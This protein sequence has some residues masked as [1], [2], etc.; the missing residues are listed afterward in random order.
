MLPLLL[1]LLLLAVV[2]VAA[3]ASVVV[4]SLYPLVSQPQ[5]PLHLLACTLRIERTLSAWQGNGSVTLGQ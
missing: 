3:L 5:P 4:V 1:L 2:V